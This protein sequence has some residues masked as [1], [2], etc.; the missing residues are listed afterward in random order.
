[1]RLDNTVIEF[2]VVAV[3]DMFDVWWRW[4]EKGGCCGGSWD[5]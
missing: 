3:R 2:G 4:D 5:L 1:M